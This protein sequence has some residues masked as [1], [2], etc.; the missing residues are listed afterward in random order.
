MGWGWACSSK[1]ETRFAKGL[2]TSRVLFLRKK[3]WEACVT[4]HDA[5][6]CGNI[7]GLNKAL[8]MHM[9]CHV[10]CKKLHGNGSPENTFA[11]TQKSCTLAGEMKTAQLC[12][13]LVCPTYTF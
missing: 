11:K 5:L 9:Y 4:P 3:A 10:Q 1:Q 12:E 7:Q 13:H 6:N 2:E 8:H